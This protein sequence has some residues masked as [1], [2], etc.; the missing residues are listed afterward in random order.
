MVTAAVKRD[1][2]YTLK[3]VHDDDGGN[4]RDWDNLGT[5]L[6]WHRQYNLGDKNNY[7]DHRDFLADL[8]TE[9]MPTKDIIAYVK[10][11]KANG[12][13]LQ[14]D[15]STREWELKSYDS[16]FKKWF[17]EHTADAPLNMNDGILAD[18]ILENMSVSDLLALAEKSAVIRPLH[19]YDHSIQSI[20]MQS[21]Y[22]RAHHADWDSG[23]VGWV[24]ATHDDIKKQYGDASPASIE[25][26]LKVLKAEVETYDHYVQGNCFGFQLFDK[27]G[28]VID[29]CWGF[30]GDF[31]DAKKK[32]SE[33]LPKGAKQ[34]AENAEYGD[35]DPEESGSKPSLLAQ[36]KENQE[37]I[38]WQGGGADMTKKKDTLLE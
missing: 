13:E 38:K 16:H 10:D 28:D 15:K 11:G 18:A 4:P 20:S 25:K 6:C 14:Y 29:S 1:N 22:G 3:I 36:V 7:S 12:M 37:I 33:Y 8:V 2:G 34:L 27:T 21:F 32:I 30:I 23:Q 19:L 5:M 26:A 9:N 24:Y 35:D 31:D 17:T